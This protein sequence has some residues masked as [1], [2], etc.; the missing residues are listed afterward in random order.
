MG[1]C[2]CGDVRCS[3][4]TL[5]TQLHVLVKSQSVLNGK[6]FPNFGYEYLLLRNIGVHFCRIFAATPW[7]TCT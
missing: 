5:G 4:S 6:R 1:R 3:K 7:A 2:L